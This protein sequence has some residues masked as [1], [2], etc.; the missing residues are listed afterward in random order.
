MGGG[1]DHQE[2]PAHPVGADENGGNRGRRGDQDQCEDHHGE[3]FRLESRS[4]SIWSIPC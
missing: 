4:E 2:D 1:G 3:S